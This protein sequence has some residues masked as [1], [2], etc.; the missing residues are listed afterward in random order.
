M[1]IIEPPKPEPPKSTKVNINDYEIDLKE[2][3]LG[4]YSFKNT[5]VEIGV[6]KRGKTS[7]TYDYII[8][9]EDDK[10][11]YYTV[12]LEGTPNVWIDLTD[13]YDI[14]T[15]PKERNKIFKGRFI[16]DL[17]QLILCIL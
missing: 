16:N 10:D 2:L 8:V 1:L 5:G 9:A 17:D 11:Y 14:R 4:P 13:G 7:D 15:F 12:L 6:S 3:K